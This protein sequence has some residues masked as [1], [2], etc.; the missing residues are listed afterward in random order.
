MG[1]ERIKI[2]FEKDKELAE[3]HFSEVDYGA[4]K[5]VS[6][7]LSDVS[8]NDLYVFLCGQERCLPTKAPTDGVRRFFTLHYVNDGMGYL[9]C[10][11]K[12]Y[13]VKCGDV[14]ISYAGESITYY[15]DKNDPWEYIYFSFAGILQDEAV[16]QMGFSRNRCVISTGGGKVESDFR[17]L[18]ENVM[19]YGEQT[20]KTYGVLYSLIGDVAE[21]GGKNFAPA[22]Q[23]ERYI[24][25][26]I[27]FIFNN[28]QDLTVRDIAKNCA[29]SEEYLTRICREVLGVSLKELI[30]IYRMKVASNYLRNTKISVSKLS[31]QLG[32]GNKK[33]FVRVFREIFGMTPM[34]YRKVEQEKMK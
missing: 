18:L 34:Q 3:F 24:R 13:T 22:T 20:F 19:T 11:G 15:P 17:A 6:D 2:F 12:K 1:N 27:I 10:A 26:A 29:L 25:Q 28:L 9:E 4:Y 31:D 5:R 32:Y 33:Y 30:T 21:A 14:F 16:R 23:K 8:A 7:V